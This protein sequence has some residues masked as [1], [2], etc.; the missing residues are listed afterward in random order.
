MDLTQLQVSKGRGTAGSFMPQFAKGSPE[1]PERQHTPRTR[2]AVWG[3]LQQEGL[4]S[5]SPR[6]LTPWLRSARW[7]LT[8]P[9]KHSRSSRVL[10]GDFPGHR[11][12]VGATLQVA[13]NGD[14]GHKL[15][16]SASPVPQGR[17]IWSAFQLYRVTRVTQAHILA[18]VLPLLY[19]AS[20]ESIFSSKPQ[21][22]KSS[23]QA[24]LGSR[25]QTLSL[26]HAQGR[27]QNNPG[28]QSQGA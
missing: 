2:A 14:C 18:H 15:K 16:S 24:V 6:I 1:V 21:A 26:R 17:C 5:A 8:K 12:G 4:P 25:P 9:G 22:A 20:Q 23:A 3:L 27:K 19:P 28:L 10:W 7:F 11:R 13:A